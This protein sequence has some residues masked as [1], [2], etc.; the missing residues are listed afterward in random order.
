[1][2]KTQTLHAVQRCPWLNHIFICHAS[3]HCT[4]MFGKHKLSKTTPIIDQ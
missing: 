4:Y 2:K 3:I 1:M